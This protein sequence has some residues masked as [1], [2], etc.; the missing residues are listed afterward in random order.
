MKKLISVLTSL[1]LCTGFCLGQGAS[2][3]LFETI[4]LTPKQDHIKQLEANIA[5]HNKKFHAEG[6]HASVVATVVTGSNSG[7]YVWAMGPCTYADL[8]SRPS[9]SDHQDDWSTMV[10]PYVE[11]MSQAEYWERDENVYYTPTD[12]AGDKLRIRFHRSGPGTNDQI[13]DLFAQLVAVYKAKQYDRSF[14]LYWNPF[15]TAKGR[16]FATVNGFEKWAMFDKESTTA[17]DFNELHGADSFAKW[18]DELNSVI[19]WTDNEIRQF[20]P[21]LAGAD[22]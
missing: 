1:V 20:L 3:Y 16:T 12:Y 10:L 8:D 11:K 18:L 6:A 21:E 13:R 14:T 22:N 15:P 19:E 7:D 5:A 2:T 4:Y 9:G 17:K